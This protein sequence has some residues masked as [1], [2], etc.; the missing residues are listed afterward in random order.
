[1][2]CLTVHVCMNSLKFVFE[3]P[4]ASILWGRYYSVTMCRL[5]CVC[6]CVGGASIREGASNRDITVW[7]IY[8]EL[9]TTSHTSL[10]WASYVGVH[11][12]KLTML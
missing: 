6:V 7:V 9:Q 5:V 2:P 8:I 12:R 1:M 11:R 3:A 4:S 10:S